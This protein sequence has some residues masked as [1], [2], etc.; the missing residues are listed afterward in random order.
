MNPRT[1]IPLSM[2]LWNDLTDPVF[3]SVG[4]ADFK[5]LADRFLLSSTIFFFFFFLS[6]GCY[7][8]ARIV[9]LG[10][11][12]WDCEAWIVRLGL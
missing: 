7:C 12:G 2:S 9:K 11:C 4:L 6:M 5:S 8:V 3:V 1:S 10:L